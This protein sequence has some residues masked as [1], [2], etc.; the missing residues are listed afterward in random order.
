MDVRTFLGILDWISASLISQC[1][2]LTDWII[3]VDMG[4][5]FNSLLAWHSYPTL[6]LAGGAT[7]AGTNLWQSAD[8]IR[9]D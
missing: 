4:Q 7:V 2:S 8:Q 9:D 5:L 3:F 1:K 6:D